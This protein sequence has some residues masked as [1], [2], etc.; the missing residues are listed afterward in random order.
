MCGSGPG[1]RC[2]VGRCFSIDL[3]EDTLKRMFNCLKTD[4]RV[5]FCLNNSV[6]N[7]LSIDDSKW[8]YYLRM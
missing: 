5:F 1:K 3:G 8:F 6:F 2:T 7:V 4:Y